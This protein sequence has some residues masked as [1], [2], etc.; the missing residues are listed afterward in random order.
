METTGKTQWKLDPAHS[1]I[2]FK[3]KHMMI[4]TIT[5][6]L[7]EFE[8]SVETD[9]ADFKNASFTFTANTDSVNTKNKDRDNHLKSADFF[10]AE[11]YPKISFKSKS[12][13]GDTMI[14]DL[15]IKNVTKEIALD[16]SFN[17]IVEDQYQQT[18]AGFEVTGTVS[19]KDYGLTWNA[20]T[21]AGT[22]V[23]D[24]KIRLGIDL[25][26]IKQ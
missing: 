23:V 13:D 25:E 17:G 7:N 4:S 18:R 2:G 12:Y 20:L 21:E 24:D 26:F 8:A 5:G 10:D 16:V 3:V 11:K 1:E 15:T 14:G 19:R 6:N 9:N 22:I